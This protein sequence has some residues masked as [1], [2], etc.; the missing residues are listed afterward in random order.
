MP[1]PR[2]FSEQGIPCCEAGGRVYRI[3]DAG[4]QRWFIPVATWD[5]PFRAQILEALESVGTTFR[6]MLDAGV[7]LEDARQVLPAG[8]MM[9]LEFESTFGEGE[10]L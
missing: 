8:A 6:E 9:N 5:T 4:G 7:P 2:F 10:Q 3:V 1:S